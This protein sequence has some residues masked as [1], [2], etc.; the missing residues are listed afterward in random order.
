L[1]A[2]V[3]ADESGALVADVLARQGSHVLTSMLG[4]NALVVLEPGAH[5]LP[6]GATV[7]ALLVAQLSG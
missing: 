5:E 6:A 3:A 4:A 2:R 7:R 1:R